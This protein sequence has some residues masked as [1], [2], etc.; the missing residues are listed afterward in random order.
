MINLVKK[1]KSVIAAI[2]FSVGALV[3][4]QAYAYTYDD[5]INA[6]NDATNAQAQVY[7]I[8]NDLYNAS[9]LLDALLMQG[10]AN[11]AME[12]CNGNG[13]NQYQYN[14]CINDYMFE[15]STT[16]DNLQMQ[17]S[18]L[19]ASLGWAEYYLSQ[20]EAYRDEIRYALGL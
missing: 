8:S 1:L 2:V 3:A 15:F 16:V 13:M 18:D 5:Y 12:H 9:S 7:Q 6:V 20:A 10:D 14:D 11:Y 19:Y 17:V 4:S